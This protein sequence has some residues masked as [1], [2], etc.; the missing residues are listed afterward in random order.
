MAAWQRHWRYLSVL[1]ACSVIPY[2]NSFG[3]GLVFDNNLA[4]RLDPRVHAAT[5]ANFRAIWATDYWYNASSAGLYRPLTTLSYLFNYAVMGNGLNPAGYHWFNL[6]LQAVN[7]AL[8]YALGLCIFEEIAPAWM[9]ALLW[10][11]HP[12]LTES[13][14]NIVGRADLLAAFGVLAGVLIHIH[15]G[16]LR[17]GR[18]LAWL[19]TLALVAGIGIFSKESAIVILAAMLLYDVAFPQGRRARVWGYAAAALPVALFFY[20]RQRVFAVLNT[21]LVPGVDNPLVGAGFG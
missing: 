18:R 21:G 10:A 3:A 7:A 4:I 16:S 20:A 8:V 5:W 15:A 1:W 9:M 17:G 19:I 13:V 11:V 6:A 14:T 2:L 12:L